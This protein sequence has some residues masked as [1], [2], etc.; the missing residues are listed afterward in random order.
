M[1]NSITRAAKKLYFEYELRA[2]QSNIKKT[3]EILRLAIRKNSAKSSSISNITVNNQSISNPG[4]MANHFNMFF[5]SVSASIVNDINPS[6]RPPDAPSF[7]DDIPL[8]SFTD[9]P[10]TATEIIEA[11]NL[12]QSK[13]T[14]DLS[15]ISVWLTQKIISNI[16]A[17]LK[18]IFANSF[19]L[20]IV[21]SE[22]KIAKVVPVFKSGNKDSMDNYRPISL[23]SCFSKIIEKIVGTCL[24][25][26]LDVNNLISNSQFGFRKKHSTIHPLIHF[27]DHVSSAL[28]KKEHTLAIFCDLRKAFDTVN[29]QILISKLHK[30]GIRGAEL[31]WFRD[32]LLNRKQ[33]VHINGSKSRLLEILIG[34]PQGSILGPLLFLIYINDLPLCSELLALLFA[35]D[36]TLFLSGQN[37]DELVQKVNREFKKVVDHFRFLK[38]AL[39]P[40]KTK[41]IL[42]SNSPEARASNFNIFLNFNNNNDDQNDDLISNL[43]RITADSEVPAIKFLGIYIDPSLNFK[44]HI[45][46]IISKISKS[47]YFFRSAKNF[48]SQKALKSIYFAL[49]HSHLI[50]GIQVWSCANQHNLNAIFLKQK[51]AIRILNSAKYNAH[52]EP[53][54]KSCG[55]LPLHSL[56][57]FFQI[58]F[59][60]NFIIGDLPTSFFNYWIRNEDRRPA[61]AILRNNQEFHIPHTRLS[62]TDRFPRQSFPRLWNSCENE[63]IK[64]IA[65]KNSFNLN[66]KNYFLNKLNPNYVCARLLCP[67]CHLST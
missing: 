4:E 35:D 13:K 45:D 10:V 23:L 9:S 37:L 43:V 51:N 53:L 60:H 61:G 36:T 28:D 20:G 19:S 42:F 65:N 54:F 41:F 8:F 47:L 66:L 46:N 55:I 29:H 1:Y 27:I 14:L 34:V 57:E 67:H 33:L 17:P 5:T 25:S 24:T 38:L 6:D 12:L 39:H 18:H 62:T 63:D 16:A 32:Y 26:F 7:N 59:F 49:I 2:N 40:E 64:S 31:C 50:Y 3:W 11:T 15:G 58:Q 21:P 30:L 52:T 56:I 48:L 44:F 22:F